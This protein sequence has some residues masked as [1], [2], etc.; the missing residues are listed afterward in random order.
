MMQSSNALKQP[1]RVRCA[2]LETRPVR[3]FTLIELLVV[4]AI[5]VLLAAM[6]I[7]SVES[8]WQ[9]RK[10]SQVETLVRGLLQ[11]ARQRAIGQ[12]ETGLFFYVDAVGAQR[13]LMIERAD[14]TEAQRTDYGIPPLN[15]PP[16]DP[17][18]VRIDLLSTNRFRVVPDAS[19][20]LPE[21]VRVCPVYAVFPDET[22]NKDDFIRFSDAELA[23]EDFQNPPAASAKQPQRHRNFFVMIFSTQGQ[24]VVNRAVLL[25]DEDGEWLDG[26]AK[27]HG[28]GDLT[29]L[30]VSEEMTQYLSAEDGAPVDIYPPDPKVGL[31]HL[32]TISDGSND[33]AALFPGVAG[34]VVYEDNYFRQALTTEK[35]QF[36]LNEGRPYYVSPSTGDVIRGPYAQNASKP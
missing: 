22:T 23:N 24:L 27:G 18:K 12:R 25:Y 13:M 20:A 30:P 29:G 35:R 6:V 19:Y 34:L 1:R 7:P 11:S 9:Q 21:P 26:S 31:V 14:E 10:L 3:G 33:R 32:V 15:D 5:I 16:P 8:M 36:L 28:L 4:V 17:P 2:G